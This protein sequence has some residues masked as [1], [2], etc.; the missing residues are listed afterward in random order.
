MT[1]RNARCRGSFACRCIP[2]IPGEVIELDL[3]G[4]AQFCIVTFLN[5]DRMKPIVSGWLGSPNNNTVKR[6]VVFVFEDKRFSWARAEQ[7]RSRAKATP[8]ASRSHRTGSRS[9]VTGASASNADL[10]TLDGTITDGSPTVKT[11]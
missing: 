6:A 5:G 9:R 10:L 3:E 2:G 7:R 4:A 1:L 11:D 8:F